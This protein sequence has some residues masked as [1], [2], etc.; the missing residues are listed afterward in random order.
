MDIA[1]QIELAQKETKKAVDYAIQKHKSACEK[2]RFGE[3]K[4]VWFDEH[5]FLC[6]RYETEDWFHYTIENGHVTWY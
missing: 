6:I 3:V 5:G 1:K 2:W 4:Q